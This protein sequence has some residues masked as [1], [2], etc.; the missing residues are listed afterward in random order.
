MKKNIDVAVLDTRKIEKIEVDFRHPFEIFMNDILYMIELVYDSNTKKLKG[1]V[2]E[3]DKR[4]VIGYVVHNMESLNIP[5][6]LSEYYSTYNDVK[7]G[8]VSW[9]KAGGNASKNSISNK[10]SIPNQWL[11]VMDIDED[12]RN[13]KLAFNGNQIIIEKSN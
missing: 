7:G 5:Q 9:S 12:D 1:F 6:T 2:Y 3:Q 8:K 4:S 10:V 11:S 13:I